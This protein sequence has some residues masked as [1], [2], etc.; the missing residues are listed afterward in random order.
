[1]KKHLLF[2]TALVLGGSLMA[3]NAR[4]HLK[5]IP[6]KNIASSSYVDAGTMDNTKQIGFPAPA[7]KQSSVC[8]PM[9]ITSSPNAFAV[10]GG[11][12]TYVQNCLSYNKDL[13]AVS[14]TSR[15][16]QDWAF[17]GKTSGAIQTTWL[18]LGT[19]MWDSMIIFRD[20]AN[21]RPGRY[22]GGIMFSPT[23]A[24]TPAAGYAVGTGPSTS[25]TGTP[26]W[27]GEWY[28]SRQPSGLFHNTGIANDV[29]FDSCGLAPFG[30]VGNTNTNVGF[31]NIDIQ[32]AGQNVF[33]SGAKFDAVTA[34]EMVGGVIAKGAYSGGNFT[35]SSDTIIPPFMTN[36]QGRMHNFQGPRLAF[37]LT[38]QIGYAVFIGRDSTTHNNS[39]DSTMMPMVYKTTDGGL[40]WNYVLAG[41]DWTCKH[42]ELLQNVDCSNLI[43]GEG[44]PSAR[45]MTPFGDHGIDLTVDNNGVLHYVTTLTMPYKDGKYAGTADFDS[46]QY[47]YT[48]KWDYVYHHPIIWDLMTDGTAGYGWKTLLV[49]SITTS[50]MSGST[51]D[52]T[53]AQN[54]W[55]NGAAWLPYG[56]HLTVGRSTDG[57]KIFYGWGDTDTT[58]TGTHWNTQ[59]EMMMKGFDVTTSKMSALMN[60]TGGVGACYFSY[61]SDNAYFDNGMSMWVMPFVYAVG[62]VQVS[63][64]VYNGM[65]PVDYYYGGNCAMFDAS[66]LNVPTAINQESTTF[67]GIGVESHN[68]F[69]SNV[70]NYPNPFNGSTNIVV[71]L[72]QSKPIDLKVY[73]AIG[74]LV[75]TK[76]T[77]GNVGENTI[78]FDGSSIN[79]GV[80]YYTVTAGYEKVT[81][82]MVIQK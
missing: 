64:G 5:P 16:S 7:P 52:S 45:H 68:S 62:R 10:G 55:Q 35:W 27:K 32:Q 54:P 28:A 70:R 34:G 74:N 2:I 48:Y 60:V 4:K 30:N 6:V 57:T 1:M 15:V 66:N 61:L 76:K 69:L 44:Y 59:P 39:S 8:T 19:N 73:D 42:P 9:I 18:D 31:L 79:A 80:Y 11:V 25:K 23:G 65:G 26:A 82:K 67:C 43:Y 58:V 51:T 22:P 14:W 20:S 81:K 71:N 36:A 21:E 17:S 41:Y 53:S 47:T 49:D 46:L 12:T 78:I 37:D 29:N 33:V 40:T 38:G 3:Q 77:S 63:P 56:G 75:F 13:N 24:T 72:N 50:Y